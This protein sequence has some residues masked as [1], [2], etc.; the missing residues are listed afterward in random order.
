[1]TTSWKCDLCKREGTVPVEAYDR[2]DMVRKLARFAHDHLSP[3]CD[4]RRTHRS[5]SLHI[6]QI[7]DMGW[8][9]EP[10]VEVLA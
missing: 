9:R 2:P 7:T 6:W 8:G 10:R 3:F 4:W 5:R 1:M